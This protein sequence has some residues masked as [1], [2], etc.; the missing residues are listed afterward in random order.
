MK[1]VTSGESTQCT[2]SHYLREV[3][4]PYIVYGDESL[5]ADSTYRLHE[6]VSVSYL[7]FGNEIF[8]FF[9]K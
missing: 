7:G 4:A 6:E 1:T 8:V 2:S 9:A 3:H 5:F